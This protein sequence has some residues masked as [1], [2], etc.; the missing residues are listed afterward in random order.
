MRY[1]I[2]SD[3]HSNLEAFEA[4]ISVYEKEG[5]NRYLCIGDII[6]YGAD[7]CRCIEKIRQLADIVV[8]GNHDWAVVNKFPLHYFNPIAKEAI[9]WTK[10]LLDEKDK[11]FLSNLRL[12][13]EEEDFTIVHGTLDRPSEFDY[14]QEYHKQRDVLNF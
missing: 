1:G 2:F 8:S 10:N 7:P 3:I 13:Y 5:I 4:V 9:I 14:L 6:G 12:V 11:T